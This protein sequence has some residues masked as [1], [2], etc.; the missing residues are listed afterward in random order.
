M[1]KGMVFGILTAL[2]CASLCLLLVRCQQQNGGAEKVSMKIRYET[3]QS[4]TAGT[5]VNYDESY[6]LSVLTDTGETDMSLHD[7]LVGVL[8]AEV[9]ASFEPEALKA[10]AAAARTFALRQIAT[11]KHDGAICTESSCCQAWISPQTYL[12]SNGADGLK[13]MQQAVTDTDGMVIEYNGML[14]DAVFFSCSGGRTEAAVA[15]WGGDVPYLQSVES[16]GEEDAAPYRDSVTVGLEEFRTT[17]LLLAPDADLSGEPDAWLGEI[18][19][20]EGDGVASVQIGGVSVTGTALRT[21]F[22]LRS[23]MFTLTLSRNGAVFSTKGY[24]HRVGMSQY[25]ANAMARQ[26]KSYDQILTYYYQGTEI[27]K[28]P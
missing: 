3:Q 12:E 9:P 1:K 28:L 21:A 24:G 22:D 4:A 20:T 26:G 14:I 5:A 7:Y 19:Y 27:K 25:G 15:V 6:T 23:T 17:V 13:K 18:T 2:L 16:P 11:G 8:L 10:Q